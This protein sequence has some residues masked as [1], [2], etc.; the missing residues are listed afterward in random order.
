M[1]M[2]QREPGLTIGGQMASGRIDVHAHYVPAG[3]QT[4]VPAARSSV[5]SPLGTPKQRWR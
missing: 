1:T 4:S 3:L 5:A 2:A